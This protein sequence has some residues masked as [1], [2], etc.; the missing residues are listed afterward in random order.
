MREGV[1]EDCRSVRKW[2]YGEEAEVFKALNGGQ[3]N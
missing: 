2:R 1:V 3:Q